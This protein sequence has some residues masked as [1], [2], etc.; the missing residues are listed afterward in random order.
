[1]STL[2][3][4]YVE[5]KLGKIPVVAEQTLGFRSWLEHGD[6]SS[7]EFRGC[8]IVNQAEGIEQRWGLVLCTM[9]CLGSFVIGPLTPISGTYFVYCMHLKTATALYPIKSLLMH[10]VEPFILSGVP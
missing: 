5:S 6:A 10:D 9:K 1:M 8:F 4:F 3:A 7:Y 2:A